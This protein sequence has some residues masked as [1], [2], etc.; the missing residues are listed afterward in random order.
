MDG[1]GIFGWWD[2]DGPHALP[3][4][5]GIFL[6]WKSGLTACISRL[7][8]KSLFIVLIHHHPFL[9]YCRQYSKKITYRRLVPGPLVRVSSCLHSPHPI[10]SRE[11]WKHPRKWSVLSG[12]QSRDLVHDD[13]N[14][15]IIL[16]EFFSFGARHG[17]VCW[18]CRGRTDIF[19]ETVPAS[20][21]LWETN[22]L[23]KAHEK[24]IDFWPEILGK[25]CLEGDSGGFWLVGLYP[26]QPIGDAMDMD[27]NSDAHILTPRCLHH[28][29][30]H[31]RTHARQCQEP[32]KSPGDILVFSL[33]DD[34]RRLSNVSGFSSIK[35]HWTY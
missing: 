31:F 14:A 30:G 15:R 27:I 34:G 12:M 20:R 26:T 18:P 21:S 1:P 6:L 11:A 8:I 24:R 2:V 29:M 17:V 28:E 32:L 9:N 22:C 4:H 3:N 19:Q 35:P 13:Y 16:F 33:I 7:S 25:P 10:H 23:P 5:A